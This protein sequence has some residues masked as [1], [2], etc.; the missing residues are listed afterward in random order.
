MKELD[1]VSLRYFVAMG[2]TGSITRAAAQE[3]IVP[4]AISKRLAQLQD[5][6]GVPLFE[7]QGRGVRLTTAGE[8]LM[9]HAR[10]MLGSARRIVND[11]ASYGAGV[12]G[13][14]HLL[15]SVSAISEALPDDVA[16]FLQLPEHREIKVDIEEEVSRDIVRRIREGSARVGVL[17][18]G[19]DVSDLHSS[20][21]RSDHLAAV[22]HPAHPLARR[23]R[24]TF[25]ETLD[26]EHVGL[27]PASAANL[28]QAR[29]AA[30]A[31]RT[32]QYRATVSN[33]ESA[34]RVVRANLGIA[35]VPREIADTYQD[36]FKIRVIPLS[37]PWA[38]RRF[39]ICRR[40]KEKLPKAAEL[41]VEFLET[42]ARK[43]TKAKESVH[44][45]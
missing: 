16:A 28:M 32:Q 7:R 9:D 45:A 22:V 27:D 30:M 14:V 33:F 5:D 38:K 19:T 34:L 8:T 1:L 2:D 42:A 44:A 6:L 26:W 25:V 39:V 21:Y 11:M 10:S 29:A 40:E 23:R 15:A 36:T 24:C 18:D 12:R 13:K 3:H 35:I 43:E 31:G 37:D 4:S 41:L 17:W 20:V